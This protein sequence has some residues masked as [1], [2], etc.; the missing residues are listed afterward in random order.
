L[1]LDRNVQITN[2]TNRNQSLGADV[3]ILNDDSKLDLDLVDRGALFC[4][5]NIRVHCGTGWKR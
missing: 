3:D 1:F 2:G 4:E 5:Q